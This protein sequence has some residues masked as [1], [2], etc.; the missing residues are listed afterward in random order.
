MT[1]VQFAQKVRKEHSAVF[2]ALEKLQTNHVVATVGKGQQHRV[3]KACC[4]CK[5]HRR[6]VSWWSVTTGG[7]ASAATLLRELWGAVA[8]VTSSA[9]RKLWPHSWK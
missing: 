2:D 9:E 1:P 6:T 7:P 4:F 8:H 5:A 3:V